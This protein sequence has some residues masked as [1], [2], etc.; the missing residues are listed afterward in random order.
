M[1]LHI[2]SDLHLDGNRKQLP[3]LPG[4]DVLVLAG[5]LC[6]TR[7]LWDEQLQR[8][9]VWQLQKYNHVVLV[10]GNHEHYG[11]KLQQS[12]QELQQLLPP[13]CIVLENQTLVI[14]GVRFLGCTLWTDMDRENP[15]TIWD[16]KQWM[17]DYRQI[18]WNMGT[19]YRKLRP[20]DTIQLHKYS[21]HWLEHELQDNNMTSVVVTHHAP[22]PLSVH[23]RYHGDNLNGAYY[24][25]L[26]QLILDHQPQLWIHGH[27]HDPSD[28]HI[29]TTRVVCNPRG[30]PGE[31]ASWQ[32]L[33]VVV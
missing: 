27:M 19:E 30:Y 14:D 29:D 31:R 32:V 9:C 1:K 23:P 2:A 7:K 21:K 15:V 6:E 17:N 12:K 13:N 10:L 18:T 26:D 8:W 33:E 22:S 24:S 4:G 3:E 5:D 25:C 20:L 16:A 11:G 28:Y